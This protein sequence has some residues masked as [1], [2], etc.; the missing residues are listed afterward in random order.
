MQR[1]P[2][3]AAVWT[4]VICGAFRSP[5]RDVARLRR[6]PRLKHDG[7]TIPG[8]KLLAADTETTQV[9]ISAAKATPAYA[10]FAGRA[11]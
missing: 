7:S 2:N 4:A 5:G 11:A 10:P 6:R 1:N 9:D 8:S 3:A